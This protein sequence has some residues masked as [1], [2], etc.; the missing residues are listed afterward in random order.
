M[1]D[2]SSQQKPP[3]KWI[4]TERPNGLGMTVMNHGATYSISD[5]RIYYTAVEYSAYLAAQERIK[6]LEKERDELEHKLCSLL[7]HFTNNKYS[8]ATYS[9]NDMIQMIED[10]NMEDNQESTDRLKKQCEK[11][12]KER[13]KMQAVLAVSETA[14]GVMLQATEIHRLKKQCDVMRSALEKL[15]CNETFHRLGGIDDCERCKA[16]AEVAKLEQSE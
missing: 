10:Q 5:G 3:R 15:E 8:Y 1:E 6:Q 12:E 11:L 9:L 7:C 16:L 2:N 13:D 4:I 14:T